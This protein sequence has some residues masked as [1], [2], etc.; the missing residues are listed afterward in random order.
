MHPIL[1]WPDPAPHDL[2]RVLE[3][4]AACERHPSLRPIKVNAVA[5]RGLS[6]PDVLPL[7]ELARRRP[8]VVR[9]I[10]VMP[11]ADVMMSGS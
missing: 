1:V 2:A 3:G 7:A 10:E 6:E 9:F 8:Y 5:L 11:F 4:L